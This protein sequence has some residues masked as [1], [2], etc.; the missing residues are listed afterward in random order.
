MR[1]PFLRFLLLMLT[2][3]GFFSCHLFQ[4]DKLFKNLDKSQTGIDF[5]NHLTY[6]DTLSVLD[7]EYMF[8]GAGV[9]LLDVNQDGL[10]D[11]LFTGNNVSARLY[12]NKGNMKFEDITEKAGLKTE[13]WC[14]GASIVDINQ[15]GY[16]DIYICKSG[17]RKTSPDKMH[18][19]FFINNGN[20]TFTGAAAKMDLDDDGYD[21]QAAFFD[22]DHDG[23]LDMYLLRNSFVSYNRNTARTK[24]TDGSATSTNRLFRNN[25]NG[26][27]TNV[28]KEAGITIEGFGLGV[29]ICDL[30]DDNWPDVY[31][32][33]DFLTNDIIWIN[34]QNGTFTNMADKMLRHTSYNAM[35]NDVADINNDGKPD[36]VEVDL[37]PPDNKRWKLTMMGNN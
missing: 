28:S 17:N 35:G 37:L 22:Y 33:N 21:V 9:A 27:F 14:Y 24:Q 29:S 2:C 18:N 34:N 5:E 20:N 16:P 25:G 15:D 26:T 8:N 6:S 12:L 11:V 10:L 23:D 7:F 19:L 36:I 32:S 31:V 13:G 4:R 3:T 1:H 30:N